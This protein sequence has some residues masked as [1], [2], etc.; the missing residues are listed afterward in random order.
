[1][2][3]DAALTLQYQRLFRIKHVTGDTLLRLNAR[4]LCGMGILSPAE[5]Q[6]IINRVH[7]FVRGSSSLVNYDAG[8]ST[9][10]P[11]VVVRSLRVHRAL[12]PMLS[13][14]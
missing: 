8:D 10:E 4:M 1:V 3:V 2:P 14:H 9:V 7:R 13:T 6:L 5:Q 12:L 11:A